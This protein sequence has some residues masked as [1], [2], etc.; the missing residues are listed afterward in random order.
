MME[1]LN[2]TGLFQMVTLELHSQNFQ[3][4]LGGRGMQGWASWKYETHS[5]PSKYCSESNSFHIWFGIF[6][7]LYNVNKL[8][9]VTI[10]FIFP[11]DIFSSIQSDDD[12]KASVVP[13]L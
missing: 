1:L 11:W 12:V 6:H 10:I 4:T 13:M 5:A 8:Q 3:Q 7:N 2:T 9:V